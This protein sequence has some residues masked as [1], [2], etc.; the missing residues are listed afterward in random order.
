MYFRRT[1]RW[2]HRIGISRRKLRGGLL[3]LHLGDRL[4]AKELW[5]PTRESL[6]KAWLLGCPISFIPFLPGQSVIACALAFTFRAN[7][8]F[9]VALQFLSNPAT[10]WFHLPACYL[11]GTLVLGH[12]LPGA[13][14]H[15]RANPMAFAAQEFFVPLY[16]GSVILGMIFGLVGYWLILIAPAKL[17]SRRRTL[18]S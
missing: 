5:R 12:D 16:L 2:L 14:Q 7:L 1:I 17:S 15:V 4:L 9:C 8:P 18:S 10:I 6:A 11:T 13:W 3:H